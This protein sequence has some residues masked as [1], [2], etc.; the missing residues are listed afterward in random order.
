MTTTTLMPLGNLLDNFFSPGRCSMP[1][2]WLNSQSPRAQVL[3]GDKDY[4]IRLDLP[5]VVRSDVEIEINNKTLMIKA[6]RNLEAVEGYRNLRAE[7]AEKLTYRR[8]FD[9]GREIDAEKIG[10]AF[11]NGVLTISLPKSKQALPKRIEVK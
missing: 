2:P 6:E 11:E 1:E 5:G 10:A 3:E 4:L 8:S 9:L 7:L